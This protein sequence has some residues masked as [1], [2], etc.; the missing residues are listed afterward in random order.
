M[1]NIKTFEELEKYSNC[2]KKA[3]FEI[4][5]EIEAA[6]IETSVEKIREKVYATLTAMKNAITRGLNSNKLSY[7][8]MCGADCEKLLNRYKSHNSIFSDTFKN[9]LLYAL[10]TIEENARM[11]KIAACPTA[12]SCG[13]VPSV[14][15]AV[16]EGIDADKE[17]MINALL[18][19]GFIGKLIA[20]KMALAGAVM[21]CQGECGVA[22]AMAA[23]AIVELSGGTTSQIINAASLALKNVMGLVCDP[24]AGLVEV[25][26]VKRNPFLAMHAT[27]SSELAL[28]DI[29]SVIP[30]DEIIDA[31]KQVGQLMSVSLKE[32]SLAG[33]ATTKTAVE[34][35]QKLRH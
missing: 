23:G 11:G 5:Q 18:T 1:I 28:A 21:G 6:N 19:S 29:K 16:S 25:P 7:S 15:I 14:I 3:I 4:A 8:K 27:V 9:I 12:G 33:L 26:C 10:A 13:I 20:N 24:V 34:I 32:S 2:N 22:S 30:M 17:E 31:A 35:T